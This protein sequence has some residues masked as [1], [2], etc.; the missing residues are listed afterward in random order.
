LQL[1][2]KYQLF[3]AAVFGVSTAIICWVIFGMSVVWIIVI[4][5]VLGH[6]SQKYLDVLFPLEV[7]QME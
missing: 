1:S 4:S 7:A 6:F 5:V 2:S 3:N